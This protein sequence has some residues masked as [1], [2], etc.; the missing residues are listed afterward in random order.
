MT[1]PDPH[2]SLPSLPPTSQSSVQG[3]GVNALNGLQPHL[4]WAFP[5]SG[6]R[7]PSPWDLIHTFLQLTLAGSPSEPLPSI[8]GLG[9]RERRGIRT[10]AG[11]RQGPCLPGRAPGLLASART[12]AQQPGKTWA[13]TPGKCCC[14]PCHRQWWLPR[15]LQPPLRGG[16]EG[17]NSGLWDP[18]APTSVTG[19]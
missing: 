13:G 9:F 15:G 6:R 8:Q 3:L 10:H 14:A 11:R 7:A 1:S 4:T 17:L 16:G 2:P 19:T 18:R 5:E 12:S